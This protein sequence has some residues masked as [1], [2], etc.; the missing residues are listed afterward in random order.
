MARNRRKI[1]TT[2]GNKQTVVVTLRSIMAS[3]AFRRGYED[4]HKRK[5][6]IGDSYLHGDSWAYERGRQFAAVYSGPLK[7][8]RDLVSD[9]YLCFRDAY[10]NRFIL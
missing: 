3:A 8:G 9:A 4:A 6:W 1:I 5:P 2:A 10:R 7:N